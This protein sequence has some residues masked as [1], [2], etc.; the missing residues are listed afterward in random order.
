M[1]NFLKGGPLSSPGSDSETPWSLP[2]QPFQIRLKPVLAMHHFLPG[3]KLLLVGRRPAQNCHQRAANAPR[4]GVILEMPL[5]NIIVKRRDVRHRSVPVKTS[6]VTIRP[7]LLGP[8][9]NLAK[10]M[11]VHRPRHTMDPARNVVTA[12]TNLVGIETN[13]NAVRVIVDHRKAIPTNGS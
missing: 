12:E 11:R 1:T 13:E 9:R 8:H 7:N 3:N 5:H 4:H 10:V 2:L 6:R